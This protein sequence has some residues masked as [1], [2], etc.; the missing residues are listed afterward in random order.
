MQEDSPVNLLCSMLLPLKLLN[1]IYMARHILFF[2][3]V[4]FIT[5][6]SSDDN[7][8]S[9]DC[10]SSDAYKDDNSIDW[11]GDDD[12]VQNG[13]SYTV[14]TESI[15]PV[16]DTLRAFTTRNKNCYSM[17]AAKGTRVLIR[18]SFYYGNYDNKSSPPSFALQFDGNHWAWVD[19]TSTGYVYHEVIYEVKGDSLSVCVAQTTVDQFPFISALEVRALSSSMYDYVDKNYPLFLIRRFAYGVNG[20]IRYAEDPYDRIWRGAMG[21]DGLRNVG[22]DILPSGSSVRDEPPALALQNGITATTPTD[23][24]RLLTGLLPSVGIPVYINM[25]FS[26]VAQLT[27]TQT[28]SFQIVMNDQPLLD[29]PI[30][31]PYDNCTE[32]HLTNYTLSSDTTLRLVPT[33]TSSLPPLINAMEVFQIGDALTDGT[34]SNDVEGL[35]S[36]QNAF[37]ILGDWSGDPCLPSPFL[38]NW[39]NCSSD[40]IPRVTAL[41]LGSLNLSGELPDF[42]SMD[43]LQ[44]IDF[45]NNT[46]VGPIPEFLA[47]LPNLEQLNLADNQLSGSVPDSLLKKKGLN[48]VM[49]GNPNLCKPGKTCTTTTASTTIPG[50]GS[51]GS[52]GGKKK[53]SSKVPLIL[54]TSLPIFII[55]WA[56]VG[57]FLLLRHR[58]KAAAVLSSGTNRPQASPL[59]PQMG[60]MGMEFMNDIKVNMEDQSNVE[61]ADQTNHHQQNG[62]TSQS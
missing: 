1:F 31:P 27:S 9:I 8:V 26:E 55:I 14:Q 6:V 33:D 21:G 48:L 54:G 18:A 49:T 52:G 61:L 22:S 46:L 43:A 42:S 23:R 60:K 24:I 58:R 37:A 10:G 44:T 4:L 17:E 19:T 7:F 45:S 36:L 47:T 35:A 15:S 20:T 53:K 50:V 38:W 12:Y 40:P 32:I 13:E 3:A 2:V 34:N 28:R 62:T 57:A 5:L 51:S 39:I 56:I 29:S 41:Y 11:S 16:M 25:Y 30:I 59:N